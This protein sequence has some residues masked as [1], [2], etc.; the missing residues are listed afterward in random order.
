MP[1][2]IP[3]RILSEVHAGIPGE[4]LL[5]LLLSSGIHPGIPPRISPGI[6]YEISPLN[7]PRIP[8]GTPSGMFFRYHSRDC[9][10]NLSSNSCQDYF[11]DSS[12]KYRNFSFRN[13]SQDSFRNSFR[14]SFRSSSPDS[15]KHLSQDFSAIHPGILSIIPSS[16]RSGIPPQILA[17][18]HQYSGFIRKYSWDLFRMFS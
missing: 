8:S 17:R 3:P 11:R 1:S 4:F 10:K 15:F 12:G 2:G 6:I 14:Y 5:K 13:S 18:F 7:L 16:T 9:F